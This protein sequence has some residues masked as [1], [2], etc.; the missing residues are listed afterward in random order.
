MRERLRTGAVGRN[1]GAR[2]LRL[3]VLANVMTF[4]LTAVACSATNLITA[5]GHRP[6][7]R[8]HLPAPIAGGSSAGNTALNGRPKWV[9]VRWV[10]RPSGRPGRPRGRPPP[11]GRGCAP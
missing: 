11:T 4:S 7:G 5:S 6:P 8:Q 3:V 10:A 1:L 9:L 2:A